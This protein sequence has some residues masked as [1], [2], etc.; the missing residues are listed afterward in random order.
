MGYRAIFAYASDL[1]EIGVPDAP[2]KSAY[3]LVMARQQ[4]LEDF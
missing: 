1:G 3:N 2:G 4:I